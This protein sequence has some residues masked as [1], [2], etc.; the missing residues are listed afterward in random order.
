MIDLANV[1]PALGALV[2]GGLA[3][4]QLLKPSPVP[5]PVRSKKPRR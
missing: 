2:L 4:G 1:L 3:L 5:V